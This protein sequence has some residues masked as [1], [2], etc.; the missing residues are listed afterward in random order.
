MDKSQ[1]LSLGFCE[2]LQF[3]FACFLKI[4]MRKLLRV[5]VS[6]DIR[7]RKVMQVCENAKILQNF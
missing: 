2:V 3:I 5:S 7:R 1:R 4:M 6:D